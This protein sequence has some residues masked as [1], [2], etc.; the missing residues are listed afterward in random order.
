MINMTIIEI[1]I[2]IASLVLAYIIGALVQ[3]MKIQKYLK[4]LRKSLKQ[5]KDTINN[6]P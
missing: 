6:V 2:W 5:L 3:L 1:L 4:E